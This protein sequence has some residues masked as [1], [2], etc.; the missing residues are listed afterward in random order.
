MIIFE[1]RN[2]PKYRTIPLPRAQSHKRKYLPM[3]NSGFLTTRPRNEKFLISLDRCLPL[4]QSWIN[5]SHHQIMGGLEQMILQGVVSRY[6]QNT[7]K[8]RAF[9]S[10]RCDLLSLH[11]GDGDFILQNFFDFAFIYPK[12]LEFAPF[13]TLDFCSVWS[14]RGFWHFQLSSFLY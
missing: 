9:L 6:P 2:S 1:T 12:G 10:T 3:R 8:R 4:D 13:E 7:F 14:Y 11:W 5:H